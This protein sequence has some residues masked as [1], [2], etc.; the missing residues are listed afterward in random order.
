MRASP[1]MTLALKTAD[2]PPA[3]ATL[4]SL[5]AIVDNGSGGCDQLVDDAKSVRFMIS[6]INVSGNHNKAN[7]IFLSIFP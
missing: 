3:A 2:V 5:G 7:R 4:F 1:A 6:R